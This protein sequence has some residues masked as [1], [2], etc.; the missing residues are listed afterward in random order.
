MP[1]LTVTVPREGEQ[2]RKR[3]GAPVYITW[4]EG[5]TLPSTLGSTVGWLGKRGAWW[6]PGFLSSVVSYFSEIHCSSC[7]SPCPSQ[8]LFIATSAPPGSPSPPRVS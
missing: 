8:A 7:V 1:T 5:E 3:K 6:Q 2:V 4:A